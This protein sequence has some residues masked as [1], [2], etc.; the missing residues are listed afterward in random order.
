MNTTMT[1]PQT[2]QSLTQAPVPQ[3]DLERK[4]QMKD[5]WKAYRGEFDDPLKPDSDGLNDNVISNRCAPIVDKGVSFLFGQ[6]IR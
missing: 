4:R 3:A 6:P 2:P 1:Q 5:A